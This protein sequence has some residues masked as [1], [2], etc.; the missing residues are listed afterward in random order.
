MRLHYLHLQEGAGLDS[1]IPRNKLDLMANALALGLGEIFVD[2]LDPLLQERGD[3]ITVE[4]SSG[5]N[6]DEASLVVSTDFGEEVELEIRGGSVFVGGYSSQF[7]YERTSAVT[8]TEER[9]LDEDE[10]IDAIVNAVKT[11]LGI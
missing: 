4:A 1:W 2:R 3:G 11:R 8:D 10:V 6:D 7:D 5:D 9:S